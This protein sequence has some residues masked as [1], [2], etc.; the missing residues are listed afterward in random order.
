MSA[1]SPVCEMLSSVDDALKLLSSGARE[2]RTVSISADSLLS[3]EGAMTGD[4]L[5]G[6]DAFSFLFFFCLA[7]ESYIKEI[8]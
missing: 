5:G 4:G 8:Y 2:A 1:I 6:V 7:R 3:A